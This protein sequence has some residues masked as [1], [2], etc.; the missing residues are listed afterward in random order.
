MWNKTGRS[1]L[2]AE[3]VENERKLQLICPNQT[4]WNSTYLAVERITRIIQEKGEDA[5]RNVCEELKVKMLS[6]AE[7]SFLNEYRKVMKPLV[8]ALNILQ[9]ETNT[10]MGWLL[11]GIF[12]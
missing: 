10:Y 8:S 7:M 2:A 3:V 1:T 4:R 9:S 6:P 11:P 12:Y 5:I